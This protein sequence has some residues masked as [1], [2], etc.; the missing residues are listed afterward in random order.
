M[1]IPTATASLEALVELVQYQTR[2]F[3]T[4]LNLVAS[5]NLLSPAARWAMDSDL[6]HR[7]CIPPE[8]ERPPSLWDYPNQHGPRGIHALAQELAC[9]AFGATAADVRPLSGNNCAYITL[10]ALTPP[11]GRVASVPARYGGHFATD[12]ICTRDGI[13]KLDL[14]YDVERGQVDPI[15]AAEVCADRDVDLVF[16]DASTHLM[17]HPVAELRAALPEGVPIVYDASHVMGLIAG[18]QLQDPLAEGADALQGSTHKSLPGPQKGLFA[19][20]EAGVIHAKVH[21]AITPLFVSNSHCHHV[22]AL[23]VALA[24]ALEFGSAYAAQVT[25]NAQALAA[26][27]DVR[28]ETVL[29]RE[30]GFTRS[31]QVVWV[32]GDHATAQRIVDALEFAGLHVNLIRA[33]FTDGAFGFRLGAA[34]LTRRGMVESDLREVGRLLVAAARDLED[35]ESVAAEVAE[36]SA[37][38]RSL[39]FAFEAPSP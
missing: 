27:L 3:D 8:G 19:F 7:Y 33:P 20:R 6:A 29:F 36:L 4:S 31:H 32:V 38:F 24:E 13:E 21:A 1:A 18:G 35:P 17:P 9:A 30:H 2:R 25:A 16:L 15:A 34:E 28:G 11:G 23:C 26:E 14:P 37:A 10:K 5:E 39:A 22:A 12:E